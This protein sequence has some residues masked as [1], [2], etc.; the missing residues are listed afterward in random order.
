MEGGRRGEGG[1]GGGRRGEGRREEGRGEEEQMKGKCE[2]R[3]GGGG[4]WIAQCAMHLA[5]VHTC[6]T[7]TKYLQQCLQL[8]HS[9]RV[10]RGDLATAGVERALRQL[11]A[12]LLPQEVLSVWQDARA[13]QRQTGGRGR[14]GGGGIVLVASRLGSIS[15]TYAHTHTHTHT[16]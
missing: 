9:L 1:G 14:E 2:G 11:G 5:H 12:D 10:E 15:L 6:T 13:H 4:A 3:G 16:L 7:H 8:W